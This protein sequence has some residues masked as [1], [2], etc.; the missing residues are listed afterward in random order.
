MDPAYVWIDSPAGSVV[1]EPQYVHKSNA[2]TFDIS[3][4][5]FQRLGLTTATIV[6]GIVTGLGH[7]KE[8]RVSIV[9]MS[10]LFHRLTMCLKL[11]QRVEL[12]GS[13]EDLD[14]QVSVYRIR[15]CSKLDSIRCI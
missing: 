5:R 4:D 2:F 15:Y 3:T 8:V 9:V 10:K 11:G 6:D 14:W 12:K 7:L 1:F 13:G